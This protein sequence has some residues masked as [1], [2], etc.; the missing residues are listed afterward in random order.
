MIL[1]KRA[2][3]A[4]LIG[5]GVM[6]GLAGAQGLPRGGMPGGLDETVVVRVW[7]TAN[8]CSVLDRSTTCSRVPGVLLRNSQVSRDTAI[9]VYPEGKDEDTLIRASQLATDL[10]AA[11]FHRV[12]T[13]SHQPGQ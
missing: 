10:R 1:F 13:V 2:T 5:L 8:R 9:Y 6:S 11:G 3:L 12:T 4:S 7:P